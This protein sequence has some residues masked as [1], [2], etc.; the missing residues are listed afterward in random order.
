M[1]VAKGKK[2]VPV[3]EKE[4]MDSTPIEHKSKP[5]TPGYPGEKD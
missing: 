2:M 4:A 5:P 3:K 1:V